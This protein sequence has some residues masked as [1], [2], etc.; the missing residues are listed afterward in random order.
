MW[1]DLFPAD[2]DSPTPPAPADIKPRTPNGSVPHA[3]T[4]FTNM[5]L[6]ECV[7]ND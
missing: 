2:K 3:L 7:L 4:E 1:V 5:V 6:C